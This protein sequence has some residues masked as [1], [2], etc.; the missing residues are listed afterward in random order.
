MVIIL[1]DIFT[2]LQSLIVVLLM[3]T[4]L[5]IV[6]GGQA[7]GE[8]STRFLPPAGGYNIN[9]S[10]DIRE[11]VGAAVTTWEEEVGE[12]LH[13]PRARVT[14]NITPVTF[15]DRTP[16]AIAF[17]QATNHDIHTA[18]ITVNETLQGNELYNVLLHEIG[19]LYGLGHS[20][21][22]IMELGLDTDA[23]ITDA[24]AQAMACNVNINKC[25]NDY[26]LPLLFQ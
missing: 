18:G 22:G 4:T 14:V 20:N 23:T 21:A 6:P 25:D 2:N 8:A 1:R 26:R 13:N 10:N 17:T 16:L 24:E 12:P 5:F 7:Q 15:D 19:H 9:P 11:E 3:I